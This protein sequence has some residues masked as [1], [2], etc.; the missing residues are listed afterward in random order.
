[1]TAVLRG[2]L[3]WHAKQVIRQ[4]FPRVIGNYLLGAPTPI[5][6]LWSIGIC[7]GSS[8]LKLQLS[9]AV[10]NPVLTRQEVSDVRALF[11]ADPFLLRVGHLWHMFFEVYNFDSDRGEIGWATSEDALTWKYQKIVLREAFHLSYPYVFEWENRFYMIPETHQAKSVRLYE[12]RQFPTDWECIDELLTGKPFNDSSLFFY[13]SHWWLF[14]ETSAE[15]PFDTLRLYHAANLRGPWQEH[16]KS[17]VI[18]GDPK[19]ARPAGRVIVSPDRIIR[20]AQDCSSIYGARVRAFEITELT[21]STY[22]EQ[23]LVRRPLLGPNWRHWAQGGMHHIDPHRLES[24]QWIAAVDGWR[25]V[26]W[27]VPEAWVREK[28]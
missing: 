25:P 24:N 3:K 26:G 13:D 7:T 14:S 22:R 20:S 19:A 21:T 17:P 18:Q 4:V 28:C 16:P 23:P 15:M 27:L 12:A 11:V 10:P 9:D 1:M 2:A 8:L 6:H 5:Y